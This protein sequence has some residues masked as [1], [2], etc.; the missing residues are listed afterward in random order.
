MPLS[1]RHYACLFAMIALLGAAVRAFASDLVD[2]Q[3][4]TDRILMLHFKDGY[5]QHHLRGHPRTDERVIVDPLDVEAAVR[6][7]SYRIECADDPA[8]RVPKSPARVSR[9]AKGTD[10]AWFV[11]RWVNDHAVNDRPDH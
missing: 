2:V 11:D 5:V 3:P 1:S 4:L 8:Y 9:K 7:D 6:P 10:F